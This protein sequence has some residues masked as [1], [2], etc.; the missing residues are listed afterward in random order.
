M[1]LIRNISCTP[2]VRN[3]YPPCTLRPARVLHRLQILSAARAESGP[4]PGN[5]ISDY[6][7]S[8]NI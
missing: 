6:I 3:V 4:L 8:D 5:M 2:R 7:I 1:K